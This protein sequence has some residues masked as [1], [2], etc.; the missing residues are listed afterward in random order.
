MPKSFTQRTP[1]PGDS[2]SNHPQPGNQ[3]TL[4]P[5]SGPLGVAAGVGGADGGAEG[6]ALREPRPSQRQGVHRPHHGPT[7]PAHTRTPPGSLAN[8]PSQ[9][10]GNTLRRRICDAWRDAKP[11]RGC[12]RLMRLH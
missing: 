3:A 5:A 8:T 12:R 10:G 2:V 6:P 1:Y 9:A 4:G 11:E 7:A